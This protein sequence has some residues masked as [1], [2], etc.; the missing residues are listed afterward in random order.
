LVQQYTWQPIK[1][2]QSLPHHR[3]IANSSKTESPT[4]FHAR[5]APP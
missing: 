1:G 5:Y 2:P 4:H 3:I